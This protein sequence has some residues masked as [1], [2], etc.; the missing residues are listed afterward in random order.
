MKTPE[1]TTQ[2]QARLQQFLDQLHEDASVVL[3]YPSAQD[4]D[5]SSLHPFLG[6]QLNNVGDPFDDGTYKVDSRDFEREVLQEWAEL[7]NA[8]EE[9]WWGYV[10]N[11]GTEGNL[12]GLYLARELHPNSIVY[13]SQD[14]HYSVTKNLHFLNMR[15]IM[16]RS[17]PNGEIDYEDLYETL[18]VN[19]DVTPIIFANIGT[20]MTEAK[21]DIGRIKNMFADL[22]IGDYYIH[23]DAA[24]CGAILPFMQEKANFDFADGAHSLAIS[25][26]KFIGSPIPC[27]IVL[28]LQDNVNRIGRSIAYIGSMD[29]TVTG[30]RNGFT[31]LVLWHAMRRFG[32]EGMRH[33]V[34]HCI[35]LAEYAE[36]QLQNVGIPAWRNPGAI[37]VVF[38]A[39]PAVLQDKWQLATA[40][41]ISHIIVMPHIKRE[42]IDSFV[43]DM[44]AL[45]AQENPQ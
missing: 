45:R 36:Q 20:T 43:E 31:P 23:S 8:P 41:G 3:G 13:F 32:R 22:A 14:T 12:Y 30:S 35:A 1:L 16:I 10:T 4:F 26:H 6:L 29:T 33:R 17:Q 15:N 5:Y 40:N 25:G 21:D 39:A 28:A 37:T 44:R 2:D 18:R 27:G 24:L 42:Q 38:P 34:Q 19:R 7:V 9:N 11:G